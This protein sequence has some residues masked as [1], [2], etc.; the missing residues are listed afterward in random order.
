MEHVI[1]RI[2][3]DPSTQN[4]DKQAE[5]VNYYSVTNNRYQYCIIYFR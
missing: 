5:F 3:I 2:L 4:R 1:N